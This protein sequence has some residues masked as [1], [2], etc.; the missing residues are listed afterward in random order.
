MNLQESS[1]CLLRQ[2]LQVITQLTDEQFAA[3][4]E[5]LM[6]SSIGMHF[7]HIVE[8]YD[9]LISG[10]NQDTINYDARQRNKM[11]ETNRL[12]AKNFTENCLLQLEKIGQNDKSMELITMTGTDTNCFVTVH[13]S[14]QRE[15]A[16]N[17]EHTIHHMA[18]IKIAILHCFKEIQI[19]SKFGVAYSTLQYQQLKAQ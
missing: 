4:L 9:C 6:G 17:V 15:L 3:P 2:L 1:D 16:Y 8:F 12:Y 19:D 11:I 18:I 14:L 7:R 10:A 5:I 13:T